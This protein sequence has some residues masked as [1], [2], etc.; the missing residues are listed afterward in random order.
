MGSVGNVRRGEIYW[1]DFG[2]P[3]GSEQ[4]G[5]RPAL[6]IQNDTGNANSST[7]IIAAISTK[8]SRYPIHVSITSKET[9]LPQD[10]TILLEQIQ[11][12]SKSRL[13]GP[14]GRI[15]LKKMKEVDDAIKISLGLKGL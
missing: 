1:V 14:I 12:I 5:H 2:T 13:K 11:T 10:S 4:G 7:T 9:G 8:G 3:I 6:I 15:S